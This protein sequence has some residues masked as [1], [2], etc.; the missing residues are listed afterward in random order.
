MSRVSLI[1]NGEFDI[2]Y[3]LCE[4]GT[5]FL[6]C[7]VSS[8]SVSVLKEIRRSFN[9]ILDVAASEGFNEV[10]AQ[11]NNLRFIK[12]LKRPY[13]VFLEVGD[14]LDKQWGVLWPL[15]Q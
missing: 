9:A 5:M 10:F 2:S 15:G 13:E 14:G 3:E 11:T 12:A 7:N 4:G 6:H 8:F 1:E